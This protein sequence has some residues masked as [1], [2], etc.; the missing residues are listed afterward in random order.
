[1]S[2]TIVTLEHP[3]SVNGEQVT[4]LSMRRPIV[5]D[6]IKARSNKNEAESEMVLYA[7]LCQIT[8]QEMGTV[9][10]SDYQKLQEVFLGFT[11]SRKG[12]AV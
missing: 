5:R 2:K 9:D 4:S 8:A 11:S 1:M 12:T 6:I 10:V 3:I 7:D